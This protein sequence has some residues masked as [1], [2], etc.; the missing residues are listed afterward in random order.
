MIHGASVLLVIR[1]PTNAIRAA[2][3]RIGGGSQ[4]GYCDLIAIALEKPHDRLH[5]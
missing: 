3:F 2:P 5:L 4:Q 1:C